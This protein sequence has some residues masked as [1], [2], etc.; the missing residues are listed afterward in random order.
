MVK[1][2][3]STRGKSHVGDPGL[4][5]LVCLCQSGKRIV[6]E[7]RLPVIP[8][9]RGFPGKTLDFSLKWKKQELIKKK[10]Q[11]ETNAKSQEKM[12]AVLQQ[13]RRNILN[14]FLNFLFYY[15]MYNINHKR[16]GRK[17]KDY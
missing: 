11:K 10:R 16:M 15:M 7:R 14:D 17:C 6:Y 4:L 8:D 9:V 2:F 13:G 1:F 3:G 12:K 5:F